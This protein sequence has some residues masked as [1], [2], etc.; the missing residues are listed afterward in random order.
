ML[1]VI[2]QNDSIF[3]SS[4]TP[5]KKLG[6]I[7]IVAR[8]VYDNH[9]ENS[10]TQMTQR[11]HKTAI[12]LI[13]KLS[14]YG[15]KV[16]KALKKDDLFVERLLVLSKETTDDHNNVNRIIWRLGEIKA[17]DKDL[18]TDD[19]LISAENEWDETISYDLIL[20]VSPNV[21]DLIVAK[22]I[23]SRLTKKGYRIYLE[24]ASK[25]RL[26]LM[27]KAIEKQKP[28]LVCISKKYRSSKICM[29]ELEYANKNSS[30]II[31]GLVESK[32]HVQGWLKHLIGNRDIIDFT[33][34]DSK[35]KKTFDNALKNL[36]FQI[37]K[38]QNLE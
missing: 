12:N 14:F 18:D 3:V 15:S 38:Y 22:V 37:E 13:W 5:A 26:E 19:Q 24:K 32:F 31:V 21:N 29:A 30:P 25:H 28:I 10:S 2:V 33:T 7:P 16:I 20:S 17:S 11:I 9:P 36:Y 27:K 8:C 1:L 4:L 35:D 34:K 6:G 23:S